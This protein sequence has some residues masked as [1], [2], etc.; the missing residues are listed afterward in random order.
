MPAF[1]LDEAVVG[2]PCESRVGAALALGSAI[3]A[4]AVDSISV[5]AP[6]RSQRRR[7]ERRLPPGADP[8]SAEACAEA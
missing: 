5:A 7:A 2:L 8:A 6:P 3:A 1:S 4:T